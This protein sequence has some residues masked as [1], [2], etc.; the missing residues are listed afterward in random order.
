MS[1]FTRDESEIFPYFNGIKEVKGDPLEIEGRY[2]RALVGED[3]AAIDKGLESKDVYANLDSTEIMVPAVR[4]AFKLPE[5][6]ED[7]GEGLTWNEIISLF[8]RFLAWKQEKKVSTGPG[9]STPISS[10]D[11]PASD[12]PT[13]SL[14]A[15]TG[16]EQ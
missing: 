14:S 13:R 2:L 12:S 16:T 4:V 15:N 10:D 5:F 8:N 9:L 6:N 3:L 7:T 11:G 1:P